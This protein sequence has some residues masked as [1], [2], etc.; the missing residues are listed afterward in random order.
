M[1]PYYP[2]THMQY[3]APAMPAYP[4]PNMMFPPAANPGLLYS[5]DRKAKKN[6]QVSFP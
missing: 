5:Q 1:Q 6:A 3:P 2:S 4:N